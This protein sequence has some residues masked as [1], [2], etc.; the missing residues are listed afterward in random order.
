MITKRE[1]QMIDLQDRGFRTGEIAVMLGI[2]PMTVLRTLARLSIHDGGF[3]AMVR[4]GSREL[5]QA[6]HREHP[7]KKPEMRL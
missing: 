2:K 5:A 1:Q 3:E 4:D 7:N 6:I